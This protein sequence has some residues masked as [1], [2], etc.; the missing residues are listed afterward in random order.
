MNKKNS[1]AYKG[2]RGMIQDI[3]NYKEINI[4]INSFK[5]IINRKTKKS[6]SEFEK[7]FQVLEIK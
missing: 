2:L 5:S 1:Q 6:K 3:E 4:E 7:F